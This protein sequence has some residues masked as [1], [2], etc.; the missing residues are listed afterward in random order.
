MIRRSL[1]IYDD[2]VSRPVEL[3]DVQR[4]VSEFGDRANLITVTADDKPHVVSAVIAFSGD[5]LRARVG[6]RTRTNVVAH[7]H[8]ALTWQPTSGGEYMLILDGLVEVIGE[9]DADGV[10]ELIVQV[11]SGILHRQAELPT[12]GPSCIAL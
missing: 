9:P 11:V 8:V 2:V 3:A 6:S 10:A 5:R 1:L 12:S 4:R 7:S